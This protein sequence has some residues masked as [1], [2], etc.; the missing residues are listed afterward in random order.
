[1]LNPY[2]PDG[3]APEVVV[4]PDSPAPGPESGPAARMFSGF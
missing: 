1:M 2:A 3:V 4:V